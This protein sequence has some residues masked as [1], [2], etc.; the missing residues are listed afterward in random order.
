M[1]KDK[2]EHYYLLTAAFLML[3]MSLSSLKHIKCHMEST[4]RGPPWLLS[5]L[6]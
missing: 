3:R 4:Q 6:H 5:T 1:S 2:A